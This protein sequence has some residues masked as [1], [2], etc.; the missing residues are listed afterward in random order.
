LHVK[1]GLTKKI[2]KGVNKSGLGFEYVRRKFPNVIGAKN[3]G[4]Y[5]YRTKDQATDARKI[6][7]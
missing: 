2:L 3:K 5:N 4:G 7:R 6:V 1:L